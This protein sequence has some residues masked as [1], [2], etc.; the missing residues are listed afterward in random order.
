MLGGTAMN[1]HSLLSS[2]QRERELAELAAGILRCHSLAYARRLALDLA[3][4][5]LAADQGFWVDE[6]R[7]LLPK[8]E[9]PPLLLAYRPFDIARIALPMMLYRPHNPLMQQVV[10]HHNPGVITP[11]DFLSRKAIALNPF[12][13]EVSSALGS[14]ELVGVEVAQGSAS[15]DSVHA[16]V[17][18]RERRRHTEIERYWLGRIRWLIGPLLDHVREH[19]TV[20]LI[21]QV[22]GLGQGAEA[23]PLTA[24]EREV[25]HWLQAGK[26]NR[27]IAIILGCSPSTI[28]KHVAQ[29]LSKTHAETRTAAVRS[30][31]ES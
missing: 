7:H 10:V 14:R 22:P 19:H 3:A 23:A 31:L 27:E 18:G 1:A 26:R 16:L 5:W 11:H 20:E 17:V 12:L 30:Y 4:R 6:P 28:K 24:R 8:L 9:R 15:I 21:A 13:E 2:Q 29:I 25:F